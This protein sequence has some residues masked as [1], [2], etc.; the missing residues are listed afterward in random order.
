MI[1]IVLRPFSR[2][3]RGPKAPYASPQMSTGHWTAL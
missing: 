1:E 2:D 3:Q